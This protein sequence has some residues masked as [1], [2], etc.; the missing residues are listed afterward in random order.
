[1]TIKEFAKLCKC[2]T[3]TLRYYDRINLLKPEKV[4]SFTGYRQYEKEQVLDFLKIKN[5]Q[6]AS[7]SLEEICFL[8]TANPSKVY[9][10]ITNK[11][12][13]QTVVLQK[14]KEIQKSYQNEYMNKKEINEKTKMQIMESM[15]K[16]NPQE[17]FGIS[18]EEY[19]MIISKVM[20][21]FDSIGLNN[22][23]EDSDFSKNNESEDNDSSE[24]YW[25]SPK[26]NPEYTCVYEKH[27]WKNVK[28]FFNEVISLT[29]GEYLFHF[30][31]N[32]EKGV[33]TSFCNIVL[34][35]VLNTNVGK[36]L[37]L[38][39]ELDY[40]KDNQNHFWL[41]ERNI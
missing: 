23:I 6:M 8:L 24:E 10:A 1:M 25:I 21:Y 36:K 29:S 20:E 30:E 34:G 37:T 33:Y 26:N 31:T 4:D 5:L 13:E 16:Y 39:C 7:F 18:D 41:F 11:I 28:E 2:N 12:N 32:K 19:K 17:E 22:N 9:D 27:G 35:M 38:G 15:S 14:L 3:Q 40:S